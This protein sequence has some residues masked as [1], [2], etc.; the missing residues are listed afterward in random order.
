MSSR[1]AQEASVWRD[2]SFVLLWVGETVSFTGTQISRVVLP[3]LVFQL[4]GSAIQTS[5][6]LAIQTTP[7]LLFGLLAGAMADRF[8]RRVIMVAFNVLNALVIACIPVLS[9]LGVLTLTH[10]YVAA[11]LSAI[12]WVF[13]DAAN[14][15]AVPAIVGR[16]RIVPATSA[17]FASWTIVGVVGL[18]VGGLLAATLGPAPTLWIDAAS[19]LV[20][21]IALACIPRSFRRADPEPASHERLLARTLRDVGEGLRYLGRHEIVRPLTILGFLSSLT[22]GAVFG[23][24][25]VYAVRQLGLAEDDVRLGWV[26]AAGAAGAVCAA[27][28]LPRLARRV[29]PPRISLVA[30]VAQFFLLVGVAP[31]SN[32]VISL[33]LLFAWEAAHMLCIL[34]GIALRQQLTPDRLQSR[35][36][37]TGRM[38]AAG[39]IPIGAAVG[40]LLADVASVQVAYLVMACGVGLSALIGW[41]SPLRR[42]D[43]ATVARLIEEAEPSSQSRAPPS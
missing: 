7:Y 22:G 19:Y 3:I 17:L 20:A 24:L 26:F 14:F 5:V 27:L 33:A 39:G 4:T 30:F 35:V 8:D 25:I 36:N 34:N 40:G 18:P 43:A 29:N 10:V 15:G 32:L 16:S 9:A 21:A 38:L 37:A 42:T 2:R 28:G 12:A 11:L 1:D 23:L 13:S 31:S 6:L 41:L